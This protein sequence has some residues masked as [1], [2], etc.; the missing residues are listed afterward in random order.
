METADAQRSAEMMLAEWP[1]R[2]GAHVV[3]DALLPV[4]YWP[5]KPV[6]GQH[7]CPF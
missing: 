1:K 5:D 2:L 3:M 7:S 4:A 6:L